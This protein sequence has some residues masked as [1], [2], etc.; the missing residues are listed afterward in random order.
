MR[1]RNLLVLLAAVAMAMWVVAPASA[2]GIDQGQLEAQGWSCFPAGPASPQN[3]H[4]LSPNP[5]QGAAAS[6]MVFSG[7]DG[8]F[9]GTESL[10]FTAKDLSELP[11]PKDG[12]HWH[13]IDTN[14]WACHHWK[15]APSG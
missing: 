4:C 13:E 12:G 9:L 2:H 11:C 10:R 7:S 6:A 1:R 5:G 3:I 15:G 8:H 14:Q